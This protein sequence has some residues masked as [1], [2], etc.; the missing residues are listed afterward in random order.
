MK[1]LTQVVCLLFFCTHLSAQDGFRFTSNKKKTS[2]PFKL[3]NNLIIVPIEV[4]GIE[5]NFLLDTGVEETILFSLDEKEELKLYEVQKI[6]LKGLGIEEAVEG[7]KSSGNILKV[8]GM[9]YR[10]HDI[11]I[12]LDQDINFSSTLG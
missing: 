5:L 12:V 9:E 4:N 3:I 11:L 1:I 8:P 7:L 6:K 10:N 2:I